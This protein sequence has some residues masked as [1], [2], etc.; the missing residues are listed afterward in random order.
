MK[1]CIDPGHGGSESG[2]VGEDGLREADV[3]LA[4]CLLVRDDLAAAGYEVA[5]TREKDE[6][7][8]LRRRAQIS[9][10]AKVEVFLSVHCNA[11]TDR[12]VQGIETWHHGSVKGRRLAGCVQRTMMEAFPGHVDRGADVDAKLYQNGLAVLRETKAPAAL[13]EMEFISRPE[14][15]ALMVTQDYRE[16]VARALVAGIKDYIGGETSCST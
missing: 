11:V 16:K 14:M 9:N 10:R 3:N 4:V 1:I 5:M 13:V 8:S 7:V 2:A 6:T 12:A 15:E